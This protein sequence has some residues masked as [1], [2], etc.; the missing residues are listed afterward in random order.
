MHS[1]IFS[2]WRP[3]LLAL[4]VAVFLLVQ[5]KGHSRWSGDVRLGAWHKNPALTLIDKSKQAVSLAQS[6]LSLGF[7]SNT[8]N[9]TSDMV[10]S[11][12]HFR[13]LQSFKPDYSLNKI[14]Q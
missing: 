10:I 2:A 5:L 12:P 3:W 8:N 6:F 13:V 9:S 14:T 7:P 4:P 11:S 1:I